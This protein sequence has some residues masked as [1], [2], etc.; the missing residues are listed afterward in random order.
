MI[1]RKFF[2]TALFSFAILLGT[3]A[4]SADKKEEEQESVSQ[5]STP[6][7]PAQEKVDNKTENKTKDEASEN[8]TSTASTD[9]I[10]A[11]P[12][13]DSFENLRGGL[14]RLE[15]LGLYTNP[16]EGGLGRD[17]WGESSRATLLALY[18]SLPND[19]GWPAVNALIR[20][21][22]LTESG[23]GKINNDVAPQPGQDL[24]TVRLVKLLQAGAYDEAYA[25]YTRM[26]QPP[27][28]AALARAGLLAMLL[29]GEKSLACVENN[30]LIEA[31]PD[32][33]FINDFGAYC[34][35]TLSDDA[36]AEA[37]ARLKKSKSR[38]LNTLATNKSFSMDYARNSFENLSLVE[39][40]A[41]VADQR[42]KIGA[43]PVSE[44]HTLPPAHIMALLA[45]RNLP[46]DHLLALQIAAL[47]RDLMRVDEIKKIYSRSLT[48][49]EFDDAKNGKYTPAPHQDIGFLYRKAKDLAA[50]E[51]QWAILRKTYALS[52]KY[53]PAALIPF[54]DLYYGSLPDQPTLQDF[55]RVFGALIRA[56]LMIP[57]HWVDALKAHQGTIDKKSYGALMALA[58]LAQPGKFATPQERENLNQSI[59]SLPE[60][61]ASLAQILLSTLTERGAGYEKKIEI[62]EK[63]YLTPPLNYV[64]PSYA[65]WDR[66]KIASRSRMVSE[67]V[68][69]GIGLLKQDKP[70]DIYPGILADVIRALDDV[71]LTD[72]S[73][74]LA[75]EAM[76]RSVEY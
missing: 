51:E 2:L 33:E 8:Q 70:A 44:I 72:A 27:Y 48:T 73:R 54:A 56:H 66:L 4:W 22:L 37:L 68:L 24:F 52:D 28:D 50:G 12:A 16:N 43:L 6:N 18:D 39:R 5:E 29:R 3:S 42:L 63:I 19:S 10:P 21:A 14:A 74:D 64:M 13:S 58:A 26:G 60:R 15:G 67:V 34:E 30:T 65:V 61:E 53:G 55:R 57:G 40:G 7:N 59:A 75:M 9:N 11:V 20:G 49:E 76:L 35:A 25:M 71:G 47:G 69:L 31:F 46:P 23:A 17:F 1:L 36:S 41:L 45:Q 32:S 38:I 62:Y